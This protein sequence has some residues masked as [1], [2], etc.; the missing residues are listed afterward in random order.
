LVVAKKH[1][2]GGYDSIA[3]AEV[4]GVLADIRLRADLFF[5]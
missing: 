1:D 3:D 4:T 5:T 2:H